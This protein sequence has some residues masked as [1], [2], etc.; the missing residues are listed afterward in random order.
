[1]NLYMIM[2]M[3]NTKQKSNEEMILRLNELKEKEELEGVKA[4]RMW[5]LSI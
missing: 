2:D 4:R 5:S 3:G 1:M